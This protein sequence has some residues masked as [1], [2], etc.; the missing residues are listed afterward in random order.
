MPKPAALRGRTCAFCVVP[1]LAILAVAALIVDPAGDRGNASSV[2]EAFLSS[3]PPTVAS[4]ARGRIQASYGAR[5][6]AF[7]RNEGQTDAQVKYM[8][9]GNGYTLFL[10]ANDAV[11]SLHSSSTSGVGSAASR[12]AAWDTKKSSGKRRAH[13]D[14]TALVHMQL[15]GGNSQAKVAASDV[16]S[17]TANYF[18]G[19]D[20]SKWRKNVP[21]YARVSYQDVYP[22]VD[23][24][25]HGAQRQLEFDFLVAP[26]ANPQPI[27]F[28]FIGARNV[29]TDD[30]GNLVISSTAGDVLVHKPVA[31]QQQNG[32]RQ[33]VDARFIL[34]A[35]N[36]V[37]FELGKYDRSREL[38]IDPSVSYAYSTYLGGSAEDDGFGIS[39]DGSGNAYVTGETMS[40]D[41]PGFSSTN[42]LAGTANVF[43]TEITPDGSGFLYSAYVGGS[44]SDSGNAIAVDSKGDA[45][46]AGSA[47]SNNFPTTPGSFQPAIVPGATGNAFIF[48]LNPTGSALTYSTYL[49]GSVSDIALG[50]ALDG[51]GNV[52][53]A[54]KTTSGDFPLSSHPLQTA[55]A[56]GFV[57]K[58]TPAGK[59]ASDRVFSTYIGGGGQD[60][61]NAVALDSSANVYITGQTE[62]S[63]FH[64]TA[65]AFQTTFGGVADAFVTAIKTDG[66]AYI[67]STYLGGAGAD[68][69]DGI[70]VDSSANAYVT[71]ET[72]GS[73]PLKSALQPTFGGGGF[74]AFVT[75]LNPTGS[76]LVYSSYL[77]GS[78]NDLG[79]SIAVDGSGNAYVTGQTVS[80]NFPTASPTQP[81]TGGGIDAFV[82]EVNAA[83]SA[84][85]FSTY[86]GGSGDEDT[87]GNFG[88][89]A[90][91]GAGA[92][93]YVTGNTASSTDFPIMPNPGVFQKTYG[94][95]PFDA[96]V[97][98]YAQ[99][100]FSIAATTPTAVSPGTSGTS[101]ITLT[102]LNGYNSPVKLTCSVT[103][104][105]SPLPACSASSF[106]PPS[107]V[108]PIAS[109]GATTTLTIATT[110]ATGSVFHP[111]KVFY[112]TFL[113]LIGMAV[114]GLFGSRRK[115]VFGYL[116]LAIGL[117]ALLLMPACGGGGSGG[118]SGSCTT[119]PSAPTGLASSSTTSTG[120]TLNWTAATA[121]ANCSVTSYTIYQNGKSIGTASNTTFNVTGL[122]PSTTYNF[123]VAASD[124]AGLSAQSI[125]VPVTTS[126]SGSTPAGSYTITITGT[127]TDASATTK[128]TQVILTVN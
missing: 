39:F 113:P 112:V 109:P 62:S 61:V 59:G 64:T 83:G 53:T 26:G 34:K 7:E 122:A 42:K 48:E 126:P 73:F 101:T 17:G 41:F 21:C 25:F 2:S 29:K 102:A 60:F 67:Y 51:S 124:S 27:G 115:K 99:P 57:A 35:N 38:V 93:I 106:A 37:G 15:A 100:T 5:P 10:T 9:R 56:G 118:G 76:A 22:G 78:Q 79:A 40:A 75:K 117:A 77:G 50:V 108:T 46:V 69:G 1:V 88:A 45:F 44:A 54:G 80:P 28:D 114:V 111:R 3:Q 92:T 95:G 90:V 94:G 116:V 81:A 97:V 68:I 13:N 104:T 23:M 12:R 125:A 36:R 31:Y 49:G 55:V 47:T 74:D 66:S 52:Y 4:G 70:A 119:V 82:S 121:G 105:G 123:T 18:L 24:A 103:G 86:L 127:G 16:L 14:S 120:T 63:T 20:P 72:S 96:F 43:V 87:T 107:P 32:T 33:A 19:N 110:G 98:K 71:G 128:S 91:D 6:L 65:G 30:S 89:I 8:A 85:V 11:F 58:L 84:L